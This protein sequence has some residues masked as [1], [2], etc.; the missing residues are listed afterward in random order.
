MA[1]NAYYQLAVPKAMQDQLDE[2]LPL[3]ERALALHEQA[4]DERQ[5]AMSR[6]LVAMLLVKQGRN[7]DGIRLWRRSLAYYEN[8]GDDIGAVY[9]LHRIGFATWCQGDL[10]QTRRTLERVLAIHAERPDAVDPKLLLAVKLNLGHVE[11]WDG[12]LEQAEAQLAAAEALALEL[13]DRGILTNTLL[14]RCA[15]DLMYD[16]YAS[17]QAQRSRV[18]GIAK[19]IGL[20]FKPADE[21]ILALVSAANGDWADA[22]GRWPI[23]AFSK[24]DDEQRTTLVGIDLIL[25]HL[26]AGAAEPDQ[27]RYER[28]RSEIAT[29]LKA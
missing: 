20:P 22:V 23:G 21:M 28:W 29:A 18:Q 7:L 19:E 15:L 25:D 3:A 16:R 14:L 4:G 10:E 6:S 11:L 2:A 13:G 27:K 9:E 12:R 8:E 5:C 26:A 17:A 24:P 1:G